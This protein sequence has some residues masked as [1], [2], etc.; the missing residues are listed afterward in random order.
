M[1]DVEAPVK[2]SRPKVAKTAEGA[3]SGW[4]WFGKFSLVVV[5][6]GLVTVV[7]LAVAVLVPTKPGPGAKG[8]GWSQPVMA[9]SNRQY[10]L[11]PAG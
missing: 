7:V 5:I 3:F 6:L 4:G 9:D 2:A 1:A 8:P 11:F 10:D